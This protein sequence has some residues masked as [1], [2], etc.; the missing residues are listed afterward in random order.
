MNKASILWGGVALLFVLILVCC[1]AKV[2]KTGICSDC[3][4]I[5]GSEQLVLFESL[6]LSRKDSFRESGV[7]LFLKIKHDKKHAVK[8]FHYRLRALT[9]GISGS[10]GSNRSLLIANNAPETLAEFLDYYQ[11]DHPELR[12]NILRCLKDYDNPEIEA[13]KKKI[14]S[15][16]YDWRHDPA[17]I[18]KSIVK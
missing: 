16:F 3:G 18:K 2:D 11:K 5:T 6:V 15:D 1:L 17:R 10:G 7:H 8:F 12:E 9:Y 14:H 4:I 13:Y